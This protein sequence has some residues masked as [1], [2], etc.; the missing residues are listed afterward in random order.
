MFLFYW[1]VGLTRGPVSQHLHLTL[2]R[3]HC[4]PLSRVAGERPVLRSASQHLDLTLGRLHC[5]PLSRM[6][7]ERPVL[8]SASQHLDLT[9][10]RLHCR[11][12][13]CMAGERPVLRSIHH[14]PLPV[15]THARNIHIADGTLPHCRRAFPAV[16]GDRKTGG[17][18]KKS[19]P[20]ESYCTYTPFA[21]QV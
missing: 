17:K 5:R 8:R 14:F 16:G 12:L 20:N 11:P 4:R 21:C 19:N 1:K 2:G 7:G 15:S 6:A 3:L 9:L 18:V 10:G 13:S